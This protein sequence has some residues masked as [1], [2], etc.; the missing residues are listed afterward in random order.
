M[1]G[2]R[3]RV[4]R[5]KWKQEIHRLPGEVVPPLCLEVSKTRLDKALC[6]LV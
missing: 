4:S 6:N 3:M 2:W 1:H 5:H